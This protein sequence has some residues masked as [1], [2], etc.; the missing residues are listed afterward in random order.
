MMLGDES[1]I[2]SS[3]E[4]LASDHDF[5]L[6]DHFS[7]KARLH[8]SLSALGSLTETL[9]L[10]DYIQKLID[11]KIFSWLALKNQ[12]YSVSL[13]CVCVCF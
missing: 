3:K 2:A 7:G 10:F 13:L 6:L 4:A 5:D 8:N 11:C 12:L 1:W 9:L